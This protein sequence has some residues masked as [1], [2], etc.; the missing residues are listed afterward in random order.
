MVTVTDEQVREGD[1]FIAH[2]RGRRRPRVFIISGP[3]GVGKD[4]VIDRLREIESD[5]HFAVTAT[6]RPKRATE[7]E[8]TH[9]YFLSRRSSRT[10]SATANSS[11]SRLSTGNATACRN[12]RSG[13]PCSAG[14]M[15]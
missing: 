7:I 2:L 15:S 6:T 4:T 5:T 9:Y 1:Q 14:R 10:R 11:S 3:S 13:P 12:P 8:G